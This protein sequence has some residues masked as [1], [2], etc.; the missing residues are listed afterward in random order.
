[1]NQRLLFL[2]E[3]EL[4]IFNAKTAVSVIR[5]RPEAVVGVLDSQHA[6]RTTREVLGVAAAVPIV[7]TLEE[8]LALQPDTLVIGIAPAGGQLPSAWRATI[9]RALQAGLSVISGLHLFLGD[10]PELASLAAAHGGQIVD[11]RRP[12]LDQPIAAMRALGT[13]ALRVLTVGTD[14]NVGKKIAA[15]EITAAG[16]RLG[17]DARFVATGQSGMLIAG[18]GVTLDR[19]PG[20]FMAGC[21]EQAVVADGDS[22]LVVVEGQGSLL[23][24]AY[25]GVTLAQMHGALPHAMIL[26]HHAGREMMRK[27]PLRLPPLAE[28]IR[29]Y[30]D[31]VA[32]LFPG[33]V[34]GIAINPYGLTPE[35]T[36]EVIARAEDETG[37][38]AVDVVTEGADRLVRA[39]PRLGVSQH[40]G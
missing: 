15:L 34:T 28:W 1:M 27:Q 3:G 32:P 4:D 33:R 6:G 17:M 26:V 10:D 36:R 23:H 11:L 12:P 25:S 9:I 21:I 16:K 13:R 24:P 29:R 37:L 19:V 31:A 5:Y 8:G 35:A 39:L 22:D 20:D 38:P 18:S 30:E 14:C 40:S 7:A 2:A